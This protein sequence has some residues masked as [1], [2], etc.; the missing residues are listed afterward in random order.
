[1]PLE[2][3]GEIIRLLLTSGNA[4]VSARCSIQQTPLHSAAS[5]GVVEN[6]HLLLAHGAC[7]EAKSISG[8]T[9]Y[10]RTPKCFKGAVSFLQ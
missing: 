10:E 9:P 8:K 5:A 1:M 6:V 3:Y 7:H 2:K 4:D